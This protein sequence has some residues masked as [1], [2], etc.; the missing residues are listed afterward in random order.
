MF[1]TPPPKFNKNIC[2]HLHTITIIIMIITMAIIIMIITMAITI[3]NV[4]HS[5]VMLLR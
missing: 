1:H 5:S 3:I 4:V 2:K